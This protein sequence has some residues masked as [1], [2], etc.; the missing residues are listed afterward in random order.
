MRGFFFSGECSMSSTDFFH[1]VTVTNLD[2]GARVIS[3]PSSSIIGLC[4][5][6]MPGPGADGTPGAAV[7]ELKLITS[8]REA[9]AA[10]LHR[11]PVRLDR[12]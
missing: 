2:V 11:R 8:E 12:Q 3:L 9:V 7:N 10:C 1:G 6:F 4:D 5:T